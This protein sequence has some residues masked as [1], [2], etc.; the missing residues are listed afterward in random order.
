MNIILNCTD[1]REMGFTF[2]AAND[3]NLQVAALKDNEPYW[4]SMVITIVNR[5]PV[6]PERESD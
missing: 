4:S 3:I 1:G 2:G 5:S 6:Y